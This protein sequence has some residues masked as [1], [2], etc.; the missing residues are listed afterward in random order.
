MKKVILSL[1]LLSSS[2]YSYAQTLSPE[3]MLKEKNCL[4]CHA[5]T[6]KLVGPSFSDIKEK[7]EKDPSAVSKLTK[8]ILKGGSGVWGPVPMPANGQV[9]EAEAEILVKYLLK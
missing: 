7:Y 2:I 4:A 5:M 1:L 6:K 3:Q 8:K 9:N